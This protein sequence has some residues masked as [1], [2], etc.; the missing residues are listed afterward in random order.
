MRW[1]CIFHRPR[2]GALLDSELPPAR[3]EALL[4]HLARCPGCRQRLGELDALESRLRELQAPP[5]P[6][7]LAG[8]IMTAARARQRQDRDRP[9]WPLWPA[10][11]LLAGGAMAA[12]LALLLV[13]PG[14]LVLRHQHLTALSHGPFL[15]HEQ[16]N[17][18]A[19]AGD[20]EGVAWFGATPP[21]SVEA[22]YMVVVATRH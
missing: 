2:L 10:R 17:L 20:L 3:R 22:A 1:S 7:A 19:V 14:L 15:P 21:G 18:T 5:V 8:R 16:G 4:E 6:T 9:G 13:A 11:P 12:A